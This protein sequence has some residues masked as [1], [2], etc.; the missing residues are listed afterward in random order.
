MKSEFGRNPKGVTS[1]ETVVEVAGAGSICFKEAVEFSAK[2]Y[3]S[4]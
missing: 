2:S 1:L 3:K 4:A